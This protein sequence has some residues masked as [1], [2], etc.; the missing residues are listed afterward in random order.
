VSFFERVPFSISPFTVVPSAPDSVKRQIEH[1]FSD[2]I[3]VNTS[4]NYQA[5]TWRVKLLMITLRLRQT[6]STM[7]WVQVKNISKIT[8]NFPINMLQN[9]VRMALLES[10]VNVKKADF[11]FA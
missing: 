8:S 10:R 4:I 7:E 11:I 1:L 5:F 6:D 9:T 2:M 3:P